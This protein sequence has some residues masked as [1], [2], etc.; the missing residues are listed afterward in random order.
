MKSTKQGPYGL[1]RRALALGMGAAGLA[2]AA[3]R[4]APARAA[5]ENTQLPVKGESPMP[6]G[7]IDTHQHFFPKAYLLTHYPQLSGK[8]T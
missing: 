4:V 3:I 1:G 5:A 6:S 2:A 7:K 8:G